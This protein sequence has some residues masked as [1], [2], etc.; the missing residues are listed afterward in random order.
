MTHP[1][2]GLFTV[3]PG[4]YC[5]NGWKT[6]KGK[7]HTYTGGCYCDRE[8]GHKGRCRCDCGST[9]TTTPPAWP[10]QTGDDGRCPRCGGSGCVACDARFPEETI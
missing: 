9:S 4:T 1:K 5:L 6:P 7:A 8:N 3:E 10:A 2:M